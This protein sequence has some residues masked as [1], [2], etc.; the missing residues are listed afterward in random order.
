[1]KSIGTHHTN[2]LEREEIKRLKGLADFDAITK[3]DYDHLLK[4][5]AAQPSPDNSNE[6]QEYLNFV[7]NF[8]KASLNESLE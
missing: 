6:N 1:M 5:F 4:W 8:I 3:R 7:L 2:I